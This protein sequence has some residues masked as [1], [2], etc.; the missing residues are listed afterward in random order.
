MFRNVFCLRR[1][2]EH[3]IGVAVKESTSEMITATERVIVNS[4]KS[5]PTIPPINRIGK[6]TPISDKL[7]ENTVKATS[8]VPSRA[9]CS[10]DRPISMW[11][12]IFSRTTT[13]SST[14]KP[15]AI[16]N[17]IREKLF[18]E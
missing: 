3:I 1:S 7:I 12:A 10:R 8:L 2:L 5:R 6:K 18:K 4:R 14:T 17:A 11:R 13:A 15:V 16:V 9:A